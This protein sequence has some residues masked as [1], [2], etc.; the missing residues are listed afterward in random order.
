MIAAAPPGAA[1]PDLLVSRP[2]T[3]F[4][5][6]ELG[7]EMLLPHGEALRRAIRWLSDERRHD[8]A[9]IE[10]AARRFDLGPA[11]EDFLLQH[12]RAGGTAAPMDGHPLS[13]DADD[14]SGDGE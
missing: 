11:D 13:E 3:G 1:L 12:L 6:D 2:E 7:R 8:A 14:P 5:G 4:E 9:A 10:E